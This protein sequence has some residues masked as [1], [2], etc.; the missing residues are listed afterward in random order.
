MKGIEVLAGAAV[1]VGIVG[2]ALGVGATTATAAPPPG[3]PV[4]SGPNPGQP[5]AGAPPKPVD[6]V[7]ANGEPQVWDTGWEHWGVWLN[8][9]FVP[10]F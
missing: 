10:T 7:W 1:C 9:A 6:P 2:G 3:Q 4:P 8:G 5:P